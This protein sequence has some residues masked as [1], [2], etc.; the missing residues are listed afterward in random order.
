MDPDRPDPT[1]SPWR[2]LSS[3]RVYANPWITL[4]EDEVVTPTGTSGIYGVVTKPLALGAVA[5]D[6]DGAVVLVGQWRYPLGRYSWELPEG[7][8]DPGADATP[9]D[10]MR[11]EL[12][13][14]TGLAAGDWTL[15][16]TRPVALSN[17]VTDEEALLWLAR[18]L[19]PTS[20][21]SHDPTEDLRVTR[22]PFERALAAAVAG[23]IDD[24]MSV[25][26]LLLADRV[27]R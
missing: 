26:G 15:L 27:L 22:V 4:R 7:A 17:S 18:D 25:L 1:T 21:A 3:R 20:V 24:A 2:T 14:E 13:E 5:L 23:R 16:T 9:L 11:R 12:A 6:A 10:G 8:H 19:A